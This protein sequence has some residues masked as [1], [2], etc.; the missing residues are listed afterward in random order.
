MRGMDITKSR[1]VRALPAVALIAALGLSACGD[2]D[3]NVNSNN[4]EPD[5]P[6]EETEAETGPAGGEVD[7]ETSEV[8]PADTGDATGAAPGDDEDSTGG[9][10]AGGADRPAVEDIAVGLES[11]ADELG[12]FPEDLEVS[13][14]FYTC[15][16]EAIHENP[17]ISD[18]AANALAEEDAAYGGEPGEAEAISE[19]V[20]DCMDHIQ[21]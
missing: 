1:T 14:E 18:D 11:I 6:V 12:A 19:S 8:P 3:D 5:A 4:S 13:E 7:E 10:P 16:A 20:M 2:D 17:D 9:A 21:P 15:W